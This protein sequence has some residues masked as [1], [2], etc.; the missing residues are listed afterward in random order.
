MKA[1]AL[2]VLLGCLTSN[3]F[4][5]PE[6]PISRTNAD[7]PLKLLARH[8][9]EGETLSYHMKADNKDFFRHRSYEVDAIGV[10]KKDSKA[11][12][13]EEFRWTNLVFGTAKVTLPE[14]SLNF[15]QI[16]SLAPDYPLPFP[17]LN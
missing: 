7:G 17:D 6:I 15:R 1:V 10:V 2:G 13:F 8:Y 9:Q 12:F 5:A 14:S 11:R 3:L 4:A 16:V